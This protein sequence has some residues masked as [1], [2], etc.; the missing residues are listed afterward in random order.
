MQNS[1]AQDYDRSAPPES[2]THWREYARIFWERKWI[3]ITILVIVVTQAAIWNYR[4]VP[5]YEATARVLVSSE[6]LKILNMQ[7]VLVRESSNLDY[8]NTQVTILQSRSLAEQA[9][10]TLALDKNPDFLPG[11]GPDA[12]VAGVLRDC[13][14]IQQVRSTRLIDITAAHPNPKV[15]A[16]IADGV[17]QE[18]IKQN[19]ERKMAATVEAVRWLGEQ[20]TDLRAKL[21]KSEAA[22]Q[23]F[24]EKMKTVAV[25]ENQSL[26]LDK[27]KGLNSAL[28]EAN[29]E[30]WSAETT[31]NQVKELLDA[32]QDPSSIPAVAADAEVSALRVQLTQKQIAISVLRERYK[33]KYP[34]M[35]AALK[36]QEEIEG[37]LKKACAV[38]AEN[39]Q[40]ACVMAKAKE[41]DLQRA[42]ADQ[43][44]QAL[45]L[46]RNL[47]AYNTLKRNADTDR[48]LYDS[49]M[50]R[51]KEAG[52]TGKLETNN[53][54]MVDSACVP[55]SP[56]RPD[57]K[58]NLLYAIIFGLLGGLG[59]S[60]VAH[61]Y[62]DKIKSYSDIETYLGL[63]LLCEVPRIEAKGEAKKGTILLGEPQS[64]ASES[65]YN[66]RATLGL[67]PNTQK[68]KILLVT[69]TAPGE[70]KSLI[71]SN[72]AI[73]FANDNQRTLLIDGDLRH[74]SVHKDFGI[75]DNQGLAH[76]LTDG[77]RPE[78]ITT[79]TQVPNL[80]IIVAGKKVGNPTALLGSVRM[81]ELID[82]AAQRYDR[83][84]IDSPPVAVVSDPIV[85]LPRVQ[86]VLFVAHFRKLRRDA[87]ARAVKKLGEIGAPIIGVVLNNI[88]LRKHGYYYYPY[89]YS[90]YYYH[91]KKEKGRRGNEAE[92]LEEYTPDA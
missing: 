37:K 46:A 8:L 32:K 59:L 24:R 17:A 3:T 52:V 14:N 88:D 73:A 34:A 66:L 12:D 58:R 41:T 77:C 49:L 35:V 65:F 92:D 63:P 67:V 2:R 90:Y 44:K 64:I 91:K 82:G 42:V 69:S 39:L 57:K 56:S 47:M 11:A 25:E 84:I 48:Q 31:W 79:K 83:I 75:N 6:T 89:H 28:T 71:A 87:V 1:T 10:K 80:D 9:A 70:G 7:D 26:V 78:E 72:L 61:L 51:M 38:A 85:L 43:E 16:L 27:L 33:D 76:Y 22:V 5:I 54:R 18:F 81:R 62:D 45:E 30:R 50:T 55:D 53:I 86:G 74:P 29:R 4:A 36:E 68:T 40:A 23:E 13:L 60:Y 19:L 21:E 15:A 20:S